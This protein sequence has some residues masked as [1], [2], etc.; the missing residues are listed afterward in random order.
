MDEIF[1]LLARQE[2]G[3]LAEPFLGFDKWRD[4]VEIAMR[5]HCKLNKMNRNYEDKRKVWHAYIMPFWAA[6][7]KLKMKLEIIC[8][9]SARFELSINLQ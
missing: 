2:T 1:K 3:K 9:L 5:V 4:C 8:C 7:M 6:Y